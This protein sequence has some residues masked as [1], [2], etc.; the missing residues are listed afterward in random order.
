MKAKKQIGL[1]IIG[2]GR[3]GTLRAKLAKMHPSVGY[4]A[5]SD[6]DP[7]AAEK[8]AKLIGADFWSTD[9][10]EV[11]SRPEVTAINIATSEHEHTHPLLAALEKGVPVLV[12]KRC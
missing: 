6:V 3:I 5:V 11:M 1:A 7:V 2:C 12:E 4:I 10:N 9:S 8:L